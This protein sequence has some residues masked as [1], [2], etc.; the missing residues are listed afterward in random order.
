LPQLVLSIDAGTTGIAVL[1]VDEWAVV[2]SRAY[3][4]LTQHYP[5][6]G[7]VEHDPLE[8]WSLT[9][10]L[11]GQALSEAGAS[12]QNV[13]AIGI[14]NQRETVVLW[15]RR[16]GE[17]V[18]PAIVWQDRRTAA[19]CERLIAEGLEDEVRSR[20]G[21]LL[22]PYFSGTKLLWYLDNLDGVRARAEAGE[23]AFGT[24][25]SWL[26][27]NLTAGAIHATEPSNASRTLLYSLRERAWDPFM[28][29]RLRIPAGVLPQIHPSSGRFAT[30]EVLGAP[31][32][33]C[34][35]AGDQQA[36]LFGQACFND[37]MVKNTYGTG[38]FVLMNTG[39]RIAHSQ[40]RLLSSAGW[41]IGSGLSFVLEGSIFVT[42]GAVQWL[43]DGLNVIS[44]AADTEPLAKTV[45]DAGGTYLVP[46]F[47][48]LGAPHWDPYARGAFLGITGGTTKAHL[49]RAVVEAM[50]FQTFDVT[51]AMSADS[52]VGLNEL[53]VDGGASV[54]DLLCQFQADLLGVMVR[55]PTNLDTTAMGAAYLAGLA[56]GVWSSL[57]EVSALWKL[58]AE[59][60]PRRSRD[61][62]ETA[63]AGW[64]RAVA[65][66]RGWIEH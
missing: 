27:W 5:R 21:L 62:M 56:E 9:R 35:V 25:D 40:H 59:F 28:L 7:W 13:A 19:I 60:E 63:F 31:V 38:S 29:E 26:V 64:K 41:D 43:R 34:G 55:R 1:V 18:A 16:T 8:I 39:S 11:T 12:A 45:P 32:P 57:D 2:R 46:A 33:V 20:T 47:A 24:V 17:P 4:E 10:R 23:L 36:A 58:E 49:A 53:R 42:G 6:P 65:L 61:E 52:G 14:T 22:D 30:S 54:M 51:Q 44:A 3:G 48:G 66:T 50:A 15:D 37:G